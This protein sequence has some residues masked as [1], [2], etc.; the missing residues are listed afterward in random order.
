M[1]W[2][3]WQ[4]KY[5]Q[6]LTTSATSGS[7]GGEGFYNGDGS[8]QEYKVKALA[9]SY[10]QYTQGVLTKQAFDVDTAEFNAEF[11]ANTSIEAPSV[12]YLSS[13]YYYQ[14]G[15]SFKVT[16]QAG[17]ALAE[18]AYT[19]KA[20]GNTLEVTV[21]DAAYDGQTIKIAVIKK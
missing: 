10:M 15:F 1:G 13:E 3:Y 8:L 18:S 20:E 19:A 14:D 12:A 16:D 11:T 21:I 9:R 5:Y 2:A 7:V 6:D 17:Q 4:F